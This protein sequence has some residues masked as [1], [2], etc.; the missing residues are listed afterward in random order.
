M[1]ETGNARELPDRNSCT[2][3][4]RRR[5][6]RGRMKT[7]SATLNRTRR[8]PVARDSVRSNDNITCKAIDARYRG[9]T[10]VLSRS[11]RGPTAVLP[12]SFHGPT[13]AP[14]VIGFVFRIIFALRYTS[15][16][17]ARFDS[18]SRSGRKSSGVNNRSCAVRLQTRK[19]KYLASTPF[20]RPS[21]PV[22]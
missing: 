11:Y 6:S 20:K 22:E 18:I 9:P 17:V 10:A 8:S 16:T 21:R 3:L 2:N 5:K 19:P 4:R 13:L 15:R 14:T 1:R 7:T 12:R